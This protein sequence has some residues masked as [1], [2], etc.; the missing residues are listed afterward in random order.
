MNVFD[1]V[2][3]SVTTR[4][5]AEMYGLKICRNNMAS[6][7]FHNDK[8]PSMSVN[9]EKKMFNCFSCNILLVTY[10]MELKKHEK[11]LR[12]QSCISFI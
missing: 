11:G 6:C 1:A 7:P 10:E 3:Q 5:A 2:K 12:K 4:Q 9:N 8:N